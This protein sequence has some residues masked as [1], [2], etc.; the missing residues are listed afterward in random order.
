MKINVINISDVD[1]KISQEEIIKWVNMLQSIWY[2]TI[3]HNQTFTKTSMQIFNKILQENSESILLF[4]SGW[5]AAIN[6]MSWAIASNEVQFRKI[7]IWYSDTLH[8]Q[9]K[10]AQNPLVN[11]LYGFTLRNIDTLSNKEKK[12]IIN[13]IKYNK[14]NLKIKKI[15]GSDN[16]SW[17]IFW[18]YGMIFSYIYDYYNCSLENNLIYLEFHWLEQYLISYI[19]DVMHLK[20]MFKNIAGVI[21]DEIYDPIVVEKLKWWWVL[22]IYTLQGYRFLP[23]F[24]HVNIQWTNLIYQK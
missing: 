22:N 1:A 9:Y 7:M 18:W 11:N 15:I 3:V 8:I 5:T 13:F 21:L 17:K 6:N 10:Y 4:S 2:D 20:G 19:I 23:L 16:V 14:L 24:L 12:Q